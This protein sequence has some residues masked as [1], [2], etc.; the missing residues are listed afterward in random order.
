VI[1]DLRGYLRAQI[2]RFGMRTHAD[3]R[4]GG[5]NLDTDGDMLVSQGAAT[6]SIGRSSSA[7]C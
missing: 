4:A 7:A 6:T 1:S 2:I 5:V 3:V